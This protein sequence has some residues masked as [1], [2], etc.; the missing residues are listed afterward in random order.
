MRDLERKKLFEAVAYFL[1]NTK[2]AGLVK[3]FKLLYYLDMLH[4]RETGRS[5]TGLMYKALPYGPVPTDLYHEVRQPPADM[6]EALEITAP[7]PQ[8]PNDPSAAKPRTVIKAKKIAAGFLTKREQR[9]ASEVAEI[10]RDVTAEQISDI[11]HARNGPWDLAKNAGKG[12]WGYPISFFDSVNLAFGSGKVR[13]LDELR[14]RDAE[15]EEIRKHF[16]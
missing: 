8:D 15:Y 2:H 9:I 1:A 7:P 11:S 12:K 10:F 5:V 3:V 6:A 16:A 4:F 14:L 13:S